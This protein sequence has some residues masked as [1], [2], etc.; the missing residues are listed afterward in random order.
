[1]EVPLVSNSSTAQNDI[2]AQS[3]SPPVLDPGQCVEIIILTWNLHVVQ[4]GRL[5]D[6]P[7]N[8]TPRS[9]LTKRSQRKV[10]Q[11]LILRLFAFF[12]E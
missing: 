6:Q 2:D 4:Q 9:A 10:V 1:M 3:L 5:P 8:K 12:I 7:S 11:V